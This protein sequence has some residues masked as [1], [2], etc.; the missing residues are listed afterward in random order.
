MIQKF[1]FNYGAQ[2]YLILQTLYYTLKRLGN[3]EKK[4][5]GNLKVCQ[6][7]SLLLFPLLITVFL[8]Q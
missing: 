6:P 3:T 8:Y 4:E 1:F 5:H 7:K 2:L